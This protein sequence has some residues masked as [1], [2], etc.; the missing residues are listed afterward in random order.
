MTKTKTQKPKKTR[1]ARSDAPPRPKP[2]PPPESRVTSAAAADEQ[3]PRPPAKFE[4]SGFYALTGEKFATGQVQIVGCEYVGDNPRISGPT[5]SYLT[6]AVVDQATRK[7]VAGAYA[8]R[9]TEEEL[10]AAGATK[11]DPLPE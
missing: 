3:P 7:T 4:V 9:C 11:L 6:L 5:W 10:T 2:T 1:K 8:K